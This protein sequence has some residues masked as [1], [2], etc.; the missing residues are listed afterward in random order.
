MALPLW[1]ITVPIQVGR[2]VGNYIRDRM[3][4]GYDP[5]YDVI[6]DNQ[7]LLHENIG[8]GY[9]ATWD[10]IRDNPGALAAG[11]VTIGSRLHPGIM[12]GSIA[13]DVYRGANWFEEKYPGKMKDW[14][15]SQLA[16][17]TDAWR[18]WEGDTD[19]DNYSAKGKSW[20]SYHSQRKMRG[21]NPRDFV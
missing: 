1:Y 3:D 21:V 13:F 14:Y 6:S 4:A 7:Q 11:G 12:M 19:F 16:H 8:R 2:L 5:V 18:Y 17:V 20:Q 15:H 10:M 9:V